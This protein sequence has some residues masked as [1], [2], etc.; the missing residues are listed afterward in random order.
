MDKYSIVEQITA[1][2]LLGFQQ[3]PGAAFPSIFPLFIT[4]SLED[5]GVAVQAFSDRSASVQA[6]GPWILIRDE[7]ILAL[8]DSIQFFPDI[9]FQE[10]YVREM[11][12][13]ST[14]S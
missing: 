5:I 6:Y 2:C 9:L 10:Y 3:V 14:F 4:F 11:K 8:R 7:M 12:S 1:F 13:V